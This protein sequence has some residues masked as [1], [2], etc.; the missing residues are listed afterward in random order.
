M[1]DIITSYQ[2]EQQILKPEPQPAKL[3]TC[4][5]T[6]SSKGVLV[7]IDGES[8]SNYYLCNT[9]GNYSSGDRVLLQYVGGTYVVVCAIGFP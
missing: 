5:G 6:L 2:E 3:G 1:S 9:Q 8:A 7:Q 4:K